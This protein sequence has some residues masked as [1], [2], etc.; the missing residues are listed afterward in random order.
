MDPTTFYSW[1]LGD[2]A[3]NL[4]NYHLS[5][6]KTCRVSFDE[7]R[8]GK[9]IKFSITHKTLQ[10]GRTM[11]QMQGGS[12][13]S[14]DE[15]Y[16]RLHIGSNVIQ[17]PTEVNGRHVKVAQEWDAVFRVDSVLNLC[18]AKHTMSFDKV[19]RIP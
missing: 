7:I 12:N 6:P 19:S 10:D 5:D 11:K 2:L 16:L 15:N 18:E 14:G 3:L 17:M 9:N 4:S 13:R 8:M 1:S